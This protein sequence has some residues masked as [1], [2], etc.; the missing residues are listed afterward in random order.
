MENL[1]K[2][3]VISNDRLVEIFKCSP[4]GGMRRSLATNTLVI[5]S[6][7]IKS[8][9]DDQWID[10]EM[11]YTGMGQIGD[12]S[13]DSTQNKTLA[14]SQTNGVAIHLFEV[15]EDRKYTY[16]GEVV[17]SGEIYYDKQPDANGDERKVVVFPLRLL[18]GSVPTVTH[19]Q[20][21]AIAQVKARIAKKLTD[22]EI[23]IRAKRA[24]KKSGTRQVTSTQHERNPWVAEN[25]KRKAAGIC[26]L[27]EKPAPFINKKGQP[28]LETH[29]V[30]W[31]SKGGEDTPENTVALCPNCHKRMHV[32]DDPK[33]IQKLLTKIK[34]LNC[35]N[36]PT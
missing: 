12:Q 24:K 16:S 15:W 34:N 23:A 29:H 32:L 36:V 20:V 14:N 35:S 5:V 22:E 21:D 28:Y 8:I 2:G 1:K 4:Q 13:A 3:D 6:N 25:A 33:D 9:Y 18:D 26:Q 27:C 7:H 30:V 17:L 11:H 10:G 31:M 19:E